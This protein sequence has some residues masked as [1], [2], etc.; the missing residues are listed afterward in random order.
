MEPAVERETRIDETLRRTANR[1]HFM[2]HP[3][4]KDHETVV[5]RLDIDELL[6]VLTRHGF[7]QSKRAACETLWGRMKI[8]DS[9]EQ[10][11]ALVFA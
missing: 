6:L 11:Y 10:S 8:I 1:H 5:H 2:R 4:W 9:T 7:M 3:G